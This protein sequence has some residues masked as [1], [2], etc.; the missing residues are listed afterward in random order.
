[1]PTLLR[2]FLQEPAAAQ[3]VLFGRGLAGGEAALVGI[4]PV[5]ASH[6][7][8]RVR[9]RLRTVWRRP[10]HAGWCAPPTIA[11]EFEN[12][13]AQCGGDQQP[14]FIW[15]YSLS[16]RLPLSRASPGTALRGVAAAGKAALPPAS[17][18]G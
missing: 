17:R 15:C 14:P 16:A 13:S 12:G 10:S 9:K 3:C 1:M 4:V 5:R 7:C 6:C 18:R 11:G 2:S 8:G